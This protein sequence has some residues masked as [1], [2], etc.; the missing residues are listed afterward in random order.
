MLAEEND[1][2]NQKGY[3]YESLFYLC[4]KDRK[5]EI[6]HVAHIRYTNKE[7][8]VNAILD[9]NILKLTM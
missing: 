5:H 3:G 7:E 9:D 2:K 6:Y 4:F 8:L 1:L